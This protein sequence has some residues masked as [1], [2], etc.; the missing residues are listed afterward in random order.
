MIAASCCAPRWAW[1]CCWFWLRSLGCSGRNIHPDLK[2]D[3]GI[4]SVAGRL[5]FTKAF[6]AGDHGSSFPTLSIFDNTLI[7]GDRSV[8]LVSLSTVIRQRSGPPN[9]AGGD[10]QL[11]VH[12]SAV[13]FGGGDSSLL[14]Q[15]RT[16]ESTGVTRSA[17]LISRPTVANSTL[18]LHP[19]TLSTRLK[20]L[21][22]NG[23]GIIADVLHRPRLSWVPPRPW[24]M[25]T[26][27]WWA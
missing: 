26:K 17:I 12:K 5:H 7:S 15:I 10:E 2:A 24:L 16:V 23:F 11:A 22:A 3:T 1:E 21:R 8:G 4:S 20:P 6:Q 9:Y 19:T 13:F 27:C 18:S 25:A 14:R